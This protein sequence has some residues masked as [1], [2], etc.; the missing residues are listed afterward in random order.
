MAVPKRKMSRAN[1]RARR[2]QWKE[3]ID[4]ATN[5]DPRTFAHN[6]FTVY[7]LQAAWAAITWTPVPVLD[8]AAGTFPAQHLAEALKN[9]LRAGDD[10]DTVA[11]LAGDLVHREVGA[12]AV[13]G[14][15]GGVRQLGAARY[16]VALPP[17]GAAV[18]R[19]SLR[20]TRAD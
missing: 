8:P 14:P 19:V 5:V 18:G 20:V 4:E 7:A 1:T 11:E 13:H 17:G 10:T 2:A 3:W 12:S 6:G 15:A 9:A 16:P